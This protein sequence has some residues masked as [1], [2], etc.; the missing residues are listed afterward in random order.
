MIKAE[1]KNGE[2]IISGIGFDSKGTISGSGKST[3]HASTRGNVPV[4]VKDGKKE[5][6]C[7]IGIN[8][9]SKRV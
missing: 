8:L 7:S 2:L 1:V 4:I 5:I 9:Y 3:V 6:H